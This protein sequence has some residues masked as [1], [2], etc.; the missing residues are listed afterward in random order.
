MSTTRRYL[1]ISDLHLADLESHADGWK[2]YKHPRFTFDEELDR[3]VR[4]FVAEA[5]STAE[6]VLVLNGDIVDFD[7]ITRVP[8][9]PP[10]PVSRRER[11]RGLDPTEAKS[12]WKLEQVLADHPGFVDTLARF[13]GRGHRIVYV[14]GNHDT[15]M[16]FAGVQRVLERAL[17]A[18]A[19]ELELGI[20]PGAL[21]FEPWFYYVPGEIYAEHGHQ[22]DRFSSQECV[23]QPVDTTVEP[24]QAVLAMGNLANRTLL[25]R[26][27]FFNPHASD[28]ILSL[29]RYVAHWLRHYAFTWRSV[30]MAWLLGSI[31]VLMELMRAHRRRRRQPVDREAVIRTEAARKGLSV[32]TLRALDAQRRPPVIGHTWRMMRELWLDRLGLAVLMCG[33]TIALAL[34]PVPLWVSLTVPLGGFPLAYLLYE[35]LAADDSIFTM[36]REAQVHARAVARLLPVRVVTFGHSHVPELLPL[37]PGVTYVNTGTWAA[38]PTGEETLEPGLRNTLTVVCCA[39][40][41]EVRLETHQPDVDVAPLAHLVPMSSHAALAVAREPE[42]RVARSDRQ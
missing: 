19:G 8:D 1:V 7:L 30:A 23:L 24:P 34:S 22:Y 14:I 17:A 36:G 42:V 40:R 31:A 20:A 33:G 27:G 35:A 5:D 2:S 38:V 41:A 4:R 9:E 11:R 21:C 25:S 10:W 37:T 39:G 13:A 3:I 6:R 18:R 12:A 15:E 16:S 32:G 29:P 28:Y 26:M